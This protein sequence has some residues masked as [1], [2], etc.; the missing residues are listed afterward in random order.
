MS[1]YHKTLDFKIT[2]HIISP[3]LATFLHRLCSIHFYLR[4]NIIGHVLAL[5]Y[6]YESFS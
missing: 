4:R 5:F 6:L 3:L 2:I 1:I